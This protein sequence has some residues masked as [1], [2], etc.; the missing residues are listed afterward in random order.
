MFQVK[1]DRL[2]RFREKA[3]L[4]FDRVHGELLKRFVKKSGSTAEELPEKESADIVPKKEYTYTTAK[5]EVANIIAKEE[6]TYVVVRAQV[7]KGRP[8]P[9]TPLEKFNEASGNK[10]IEVHATSKKR[11]G[12]EEDYETVSPIGED[13]WDPEEELKGNHEDEDGYAWMDKKDYNL[14]DLNKLCKE[15]QT[16]HDFYRYTVSEV[17]QCFHLCEVKKLAQQCDEQRL[18]G[19]FFKGFTA[20]DFQAEPF[21]LDSFS[22]LK[23]KKIIFEGWRPRLQ[24]D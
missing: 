7:N 10:R 15:N 18:D 21:Q 24:G 20:K 2:K 4:G 6:G 9:A 16:S 8:L 1:E 11:V 22:A 14:V 3:K 19:N 12:D 13:Y 5:K 17:I 23:V